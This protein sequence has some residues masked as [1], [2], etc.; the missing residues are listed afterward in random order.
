MPM[1]KAMAANQRLTAEV[2]FIEPPM[3]ALTVQNI[4]V[5]DEWL[6]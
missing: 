1:V 3:H 5:G 6:Y 4:P 2:R